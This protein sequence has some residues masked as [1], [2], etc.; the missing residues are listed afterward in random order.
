LRVYEETENGFEQVAP[1]WGKGQSVEVQAFK[2]E[3]DAS[4]YLKGKFVI[5]SIEE[6]NPAQDDGTYSINLENDGEPDIYPGKEAASGGG[7]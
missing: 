3:N 2:R 6:A 1:L 5:A 7:D 4:P